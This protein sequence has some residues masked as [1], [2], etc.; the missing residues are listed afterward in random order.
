MQKLT[1]FKKDDN[2]V[3][4]GYQAKTKG[5]KKK[6]KEKQHSQMNEAKIVSWL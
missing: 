5:R 4:Q 1:S 2:I 3:A 6:K